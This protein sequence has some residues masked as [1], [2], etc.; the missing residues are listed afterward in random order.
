MHRPA[1]EGFRIEAVDGDGGGWRVVGR[2]AERAVALSDLT[3]PE[4]LAYAQGRLQVARRR[5][6]PGPRRRR[7]GRSRAHRSVHLRVRARRPGAHLVKIVCKI[8]TSSITDAHGEIREDAVASFCKEVAALRD[9][10]HRVVAVTS[11]AIAAGLPALQLHG[12]APTPRRADAAGG[13]GRRPEP[14][15][16]GVRHAPSPTSAS[17]RARCCSRRSTSACA[18]STCTPAARSCA[19][20]SSASC[21]S[22]TRTTPSPTTRSASA[23]TTGS[24]RSSPT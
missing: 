24:P 7:R 11:G 3:N 4:A 18:S 14:A 23:T 17:C 6:R 2:Q 13:L 20:S 1:A 19:C 22:S 12:D 10:G 9:D 5:P 15:H 16:A 8:G 21:P